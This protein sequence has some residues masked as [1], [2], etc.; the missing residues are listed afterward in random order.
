MTSEV[1]FITGGASGIGKALSIRLASTGIKVFIADRDAVNAAATAKEINGAYGVADVTSWESQAAAFQQALD[2][3]GRVDYVLAIAGVGENQWM[4]ANNE[5]T[6][7]EKPHL[8]VIDINLT[9]VLYTV[10][11]AVQH[12]R[13][14]PVNEHGS[15]GKSEIFPGKKD[16]P[17]E[18][19]I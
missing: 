16:N 5:T 2:L 4:P 1:A 10:S 7:F 19:L 9:G 18:K 14:Q 3:F 11:L 12:F 13:R 15:R 6:G 8:S 17:P